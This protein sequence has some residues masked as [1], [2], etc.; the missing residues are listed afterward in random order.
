[1][2]IVLTTCPDRTEAESLAKGLVASRLAACVQILPQII[3]VY[4]WEESIQVE[5]E[6]LLLIKTL[7]DKW[8][9]IREYIVVEHSYSVPEIVALGSSGVSSSY[10]NW[11]SSYVNGE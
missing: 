2:L 1:M 9:E 4:H 7:P 6:Y 10:A 3:S 8:D 11:L 5:P